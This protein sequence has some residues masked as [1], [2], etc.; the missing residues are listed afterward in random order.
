MRGASPSR[1]D[2]YDLLLFQ[3]VILVLILI[4]GAAYA[5]GRRRGRWEYLEARPVRT[6]AVQAPVSYTCTMHWKEPRFHPL[7]DKAHGVSL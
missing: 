3:L 2:V 1:F 7:G 4:A 5:A 6:V